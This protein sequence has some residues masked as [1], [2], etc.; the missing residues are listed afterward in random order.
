MLRNLIVKIIGNRILTVA[1]VSQEPDRCSAQAGAEGPA[2]P[3]LDPQERLHPGKAPRLLGH[4]PPRK[5]RPGWRAGPQQALCRRAVK[6]PERLEENQQNRHKLKKLLGKKLQRHPKEN[7]QKHQ[8][9]RR[10]RLL[11]RKPLRHPK[12]KPQRLPKEKVQGHQEK[13]QAL[14]VLAEWRSRRG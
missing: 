8:K 14:V 7:H 2:G 11:K 1:M 3:R 12:K 5:C 9:E 13:S 4:Q 10:Q 6:V